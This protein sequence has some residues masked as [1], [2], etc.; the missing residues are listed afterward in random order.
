MFAQRCY[1]SSK[2]QT[3]IDGLWCIDRLDFEHALDHLTDPSLVPTFPE[4]ILQTLCRHSKHQPGLPL[5]YY[6]TV[7]PSIKSTDTLD[8]LFSMICRSGV[9]EAYLFT[10]M[11]EPLMRE[12][13]FETLIAYALG[14]PGGDAR[15]SRASELIGLPLS[16]EEEKWFEQSLTT[17]N[18][19]K[20]YGAKDTLLMRRIATRRT[21]GT[22]KLVKQTRNRT[23]DGLNWSTLAEYT[24]QGT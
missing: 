17:G 12:H 7:S 11:Q 16:D 19:S 1:L 10:R 4:E 24:E 6:H 5:A 14:D 9:S 3:L 23:I 21:E 18:C 20:L 15:A 22:S 8:L 13:L 2:Y